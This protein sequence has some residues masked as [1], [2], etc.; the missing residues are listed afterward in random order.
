[1]EEPCLL[2]E[3]QLLLSDVTLE[4]LRTLVGP[5][6]QILKIIEETFQQSLTLYDQ[7]FFIKGDPA[8]Q[9]GVKRAILALL[10]R[11][12][13]NPSLDLQEAATLIKLAKENRQEEFLSAYS[14][15]LGQNQSGRLISAKTVGQKT[16]INA[17]QTKDIVF[18]IG[19]AGTGKT[20]LT[21][22]YAV[23][24]LKTK[25]INRIV[26]TRP[27]VEAGESLGFL[28][29]DIREKVDPYLQPLYDALNQLLGSQ[30]VEKYLESKVIEIVPL[31]YMRGRTLADCF[32]ILD[33]A[34]NA[35][36]TQI[37]MFLTRLGEHSKMVINGDI[38]QID[39][40]DP[41][42]SGLARAKAILGEIAEIAFVTLTATDV[43]RHP[44][45]QKII[46]AYGSF[47]ESRHGSDH[48][49]KSQ[50]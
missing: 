33:E 2:K 36:S 31:A 17:M 15:S 22:A 38:T 19:P 7:T 5:R 39:L 8:G 12:R 14:Q 23:Q 6:D 28:P 21:L 35:T 4:E 49:P 50:K 3:S 32:V 48:T 43:V 13:Q 27:V 11:I 26:L 16:F 30:T 37:K 46:E 24:L 44:L 1:M 40:R 18:V 47:E 9:A 42:E 29:G 10:T 45:V 41:R 25:K 34:Q 20:F